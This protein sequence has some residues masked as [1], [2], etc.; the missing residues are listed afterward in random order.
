MAGPLKGWH[1]LTDQTHFA[2][3]RSIALHAKQRQNGADL[4]AD[5]GRVVHA[6]ECSRRRLKLLVHLRSS[7]VEH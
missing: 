4:D 6:G 7:V 1:R 2:W 3:L 5:V